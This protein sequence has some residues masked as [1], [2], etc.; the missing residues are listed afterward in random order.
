MMRKS[1]TFGLLTLFWLVLPASLSAQIF[2]PYYGKNAVHYDSFKWKIYKTEH[3]DIY[4]YPQEEFAL[5][6]IA[7]IAET[8]YQDVK[9]ILQ[10][11]VPFRIPLI[12]FRNQ[13][14]FE[15]VSYVRITEGTLGVAEAALDRMAFT[16]DLPPDLLKNV[17]KHELTHIFE[18]AVLFGRLTNPISFRG[19]PPGWVM[20]G[21]A[22]FPIRAWHP[23][24]LMVVRD[25]ALTERIPYVTGRGLF[26]PFATMPF[27]APYT[28]G[29]AVW[30]FIAE[31]FGIAG[32]RNLWF[33]LKKFTFIGGSDP[34]IAAFGMTT[35]RFNEI[36]ADYLRGR[37]EKYR[38]YE[39]P[40][41]YQRVIV[42]PFPYRQIVSYAISP[43]G[44]Y[45][46]AQSGNLSEAEFDVI[47]IDRKTGNVKNLTK[48]YTLRWLYLTNERWADFGGR[49]ITISPD[50]QHI[51]FFA[52]SK[53]Y[54][55]LF[56]YDREGHRIDAIYIPM[57]KAA[58]PQYHP[59]GRHISFVAMDETN[60]M[61]IWIL[62]LATKKMTR[63]TDDEIY[64]ESP[65]WIDNGRALLYVGR[66]IGRSQIYRVSYPE[67]KVEPVFVPQSNWFIL[68]PDISPD[69]RYI[70]F[71]ANVEEPVDL[72]R[73][74]THTGELVRLTKT[75]TGNFSTRILVEDGKPYIY[76][77]NYFK[78][79][80]HLYKI[81]LD[82]KLEVIEEP[83]VREGLGNIIATYSD[84]PQLD[85]DPNK[86]KNK[87][88]KP[89]FAN[90]PSLFTGATQNAFAVAGGVTLQDILGDNALTFYI[91]R[92]RGF[93]TFYLSWLD[94]GQRFQY[95]LELFFNDD[96]FI[97]PFIIP[98]ESSPTGA[99]FLTLA[100]VKNTTVGGDIIGFYP[101][102]TWRRFEL[103]VGL[104]H[105][106]QRF[107]D[108]FI[109]RLFE[110]LNE[111]GQAQFLLTS[112]WVI[113]VSLAYTVE[114]TRFQFFGPWKGYTGRVGFSYSIPFGENVVKQWT[115]YADFR[116]YFGLSRF[117][118]LAWRIQA[119]HSGGDIP[120]L[121]SFGGGLSF[122]GFGFREL[123]G[124]QGI[125]SNLELRFPL[126]PAGPR[127]RSPQLNAFRGKIFADAGILNITNF[128][129]NTAL[130]VGDRLFDASEGIGSFGF[131]LTIFLGGLPIN[132]ELSW[133]HNFRE[134]DGSPN[135]DFSIGFDF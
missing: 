36:F 9:E 94:L 129:N 26:A 85:I 3:F 49:N 65:V 102:D 37:F 105:I 96:F 88:F 58:A 57:N 69:G 47:L 68:S 56:I 111:Q 128:F 113:P 127:R 97:S 67:G 124:N 119:F 72:V 130:F 77:L 43:D 55:T 95:N 120:Q 5:P 132:F 123:L 59:D 112:G 19:I 64:E 135:L 42:L 134:I 107:D 48:G 11:E 44:R 125:I 86:I 41:D 22:Q 23:M 108:P 25:A 21:F 50:S 126:V 81:P 33:Q 4:F 13:A 38:N 46:A 100:L 103:R 133:I 131:G 31:R 74:D 15:Q 34:F 6:M 101:L 45:I 2:I 63:L 61:D 90:R 99:P 54:R 1:V 75:M 60:Q 51:A 87:H 17:I 76:F 92:I 12:M 109:Q 70:V 115:L 7:G 98:A 82:R 16:I 122:R 121:F 53:K 110:Q 35:E 104:F 24:D 84:F 32:V 40:G 106:K 73:Y 118:V 20:E 8:A 80:Y 10:I 66:S 39:T 28:I 14:E 89:Y 18:F 30:E 71:S 79:R 27:R 29:Q 52:R 116:E 83:E 93:N 117:T 91:Q 114:T 62:D 78:D